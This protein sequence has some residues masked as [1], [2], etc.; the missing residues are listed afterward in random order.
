[1]QY[2]S[3]KALLIKAVGLSVFA[4]AVYAGSASTANAQFVFTPCNGCTESQRENLAQTLGMGKHL[5]ADFADNTL[6]GYIVSRESNGGSGHYIY[7][8]DPLEITD[9]QKDAFDEYDKLI[10]VY[11]ANAIFQAVPQSRPEGYPT[12]TDQGSAVDWASNPAYYNAINSY[13]AALQSAGAYA[14]WAHA[15]TIVALAALQTGYVVTNYSPTIDFVIT[16][17]QGA[18]ITFEWGQ[19]GKAVLKSVVDQYGNIIPIRDYSGTTR[20]GGSYNVGD[21]GEPGYSDALK[22]YLHSLGATIGAQC[23]N[24]TLACIDGGGERTCEWV[25]CF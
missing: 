17:P 23:V 25:R 15:Q 5:I 4:L 6:D 10:T 11:H 7:E 18:I 1:M 20:F 13:L 22:E 24:G 2:S 8:F 21:G 12:G 9:S 19:S 16:T 3:S 14:G